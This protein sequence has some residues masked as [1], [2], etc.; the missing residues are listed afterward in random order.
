MQLKKEM[1]LTDEL[2]NGRYKPLGN[3]KQV[4]D[5]EEDKYNPTME[6]VE[7]MMLRMSTLVWLWITIL[8]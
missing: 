6:F 7:D 8:H 4:D 1:K 3:E 2:I 5:W